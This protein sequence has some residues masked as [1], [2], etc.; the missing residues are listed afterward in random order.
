MAFTDPS[1]YS[2][3]T[4]LNKPGVGSAHMVRRPPMARL[5]HTCL[6][7]C[8]A[9]NPNTTVPGEEFGCLEKNPHDFSISGSRQLFNIEETQ[10][11]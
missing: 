11:F 9:Q 10:S 8:G 3:N 2:P 1:L 7:C 5:G 6:G 4:A